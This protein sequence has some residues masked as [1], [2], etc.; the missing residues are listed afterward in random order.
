MRG[1]WAVFI[2]RTSIQSPQV[3]PLDQ[4]LR[5]LHNEHKAILITGRHNRAA[6]FNADLEKYR[7]ASLAGWRVSVRAGSDHGGECGEAGASHSHSSL[8]GIPG[9][10]DQ[11]RISLLRDV[12]LLT[13]RSREQGEAV[14]HAVANA[15]TAALGNNSTSPGHDLKLAG[16]AGFRKLE[17]PGKIADAERPQQQAL[18]DPP[19]DRVAQETGGL[20]CGMEGH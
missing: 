15:A 8:P 6:G 14:T 10:S 13:K 1:W 12:K 18:D 7:E 3:C 9:I 20:K 2:W 17:N 16:N 5:S 19:P 11:G 4:C